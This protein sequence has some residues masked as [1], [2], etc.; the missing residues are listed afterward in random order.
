MVDDDVPSRDLGK[1]LVVAA[2]RQPPLRERQPRLVL[3]V[4]TVERVELGDVGE[5]EQ[6]ANAVDLL[7]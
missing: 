4:G 6:S 5:V 3:Q 2:N 7:G 1:Q